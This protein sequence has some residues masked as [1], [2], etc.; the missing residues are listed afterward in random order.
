[1]P[2]YFLDTSALVKRYVP[3]RGS[4]FVLDLIE[5]AEHEI[6]ISSITI[7]E[8]ASAL[9]GRLRGRELSAVQR[10]TI[11]RR[12]LAN[13]ARF[14][15]VELADELIRR[16][17][18]TL[19]SDVDVA[20]FRTLD[21]LQ[22]MTARRW[23]DLRFTLTMGADAFVAADRTLCEAARAIGMPVENPEDHE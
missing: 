13:A 6:A 12:F 19:L 21:A 18:E 20:R 5:S 7:A 8:F 10:D 14:D 2:A 22:L 3:E 16:A 23:F 11:F 17:A 15:I 1:L 4:E 9:R